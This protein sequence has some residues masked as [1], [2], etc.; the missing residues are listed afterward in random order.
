[1]LKHMKDVYGLLQGENIRYVSTD[2]FVHC[3][4]KMILVDGDGV[5]VSSQNWS[6]PAVLDNREAGLW[7]QHRAIH[8]YYHAVFEADWSVAKNEPTGLSHELLE[9]LDL[10]DGGYV[11]VERGDYAEV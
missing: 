9:V 3:H 6:E 5:L 11:R 2:H 7:L 8:D 1:M 4:N 10:R